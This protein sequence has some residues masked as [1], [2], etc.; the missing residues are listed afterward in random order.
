[1]MYLTPLLLT[2]AAAISAA[3]MASIANSRARRY[4]MDKERIDDAA[5][6]LTLFQG[7][8]DF[9]VS[10]ESV[11]PFLKAF[12]LE[13]ADLILQRPF[14]RHMVDASRRMPVVSEPDEW[15]RKFL[16]DLS[17][18]ERSD[19]EAYDGA[20]IALRTAMV[21]SILQWKETAQHLS[22]LMVRIASQKKT[23]AISSAAESRRRIY[24]EREFG[25]APAFG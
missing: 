14:A 15:E 19:K 8:I 21:A 23:D 16:A 3:L 12:F 25:P 13:L 17:R 1:M 10:R 20:M 18:L 5:E 24:H 7:T 6:A 4:C 9:L 11:S 2:L 22:S